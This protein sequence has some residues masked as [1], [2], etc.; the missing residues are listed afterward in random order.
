M[1]VQVHVYACTLSM[2]F[3]LRELLIF[4][5]NILIV[6]IVNNY[7]TLLQMTECMAKTFFIVINIENL[8]FG[9]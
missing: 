6:L 3:I 4:L 5:S 1:R 9:Y 8:Y 2:A 7:F